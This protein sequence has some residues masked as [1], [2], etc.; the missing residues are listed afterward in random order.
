AVIV[1]KNYFDWYKTRV[2]RADK[3]ILIRDIK[4]TWYINGINSDL[5]SIQKVF[6]FLKD[7]T[8]GFEEIITIG[9]SAGG[10]AAALFGAM[11]NATMAFCISP[12]FNLNDMINSE[13][14]KIANPIVVTMIENGEIND[15]IDITNIIKKA[16]Q[17]QFYYFYPLQCEL[18]VTQSKYVKN[19]EN[20]YSFGFISDK[21][22]ATMNHNDI[23]EIINLKQNSIKKLYS[24][25]KNK[26]I[27]P[28]AFSKKIFIF[29]LMT[30]DIKR[31]VKNF[32]FRLFV[33]IKTMLKFLG[34]YQII[35]TIVKK[36]K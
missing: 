9:S 25:F 16:I 30:F 35:K 19:I 31:I 4:K 28:D 6:E 17:T 2:K 5:H 20:V 7:E 34:L 29:I 27:N 11:L 36:G 21:H 14:D 22:S 12:Q 24:K 1:K 3:H 32:K 10:F 33:E 26:E 23:E 8:E 18:D 15:F 13:N